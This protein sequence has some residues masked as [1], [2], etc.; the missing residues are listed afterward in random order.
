MKVLKFFADWC[1][2]CK[3]MSKT[4]ETHYKGNI[5]VEDVDIDKNTEVAVRYGIRSVPTCI[6]LDENGSELKRKVGAMSID[7]FNT[8][9]KV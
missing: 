9:I 6:L 2:P 8:F 3:A 7:E 4:L 1:G 5:P